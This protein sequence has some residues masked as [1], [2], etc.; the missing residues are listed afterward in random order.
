MSTLR[1]PFANFTV[2][3]LLGFLAVLFIVPIVVK[4]VFAVLAGLF[5]LRLV[6]KLIFQSLIVA[7]TGMLTK[8][9]VLDKLFGQK[10]RQGDGLLK[11][12][13]HRY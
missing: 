6:R 12:K 13:P 7:A 8:E 1:N 10:G 4:T 11:P 3:T 5:R 2:E 9:G